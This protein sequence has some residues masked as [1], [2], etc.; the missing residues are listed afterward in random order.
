M[1]ARGNPAGNYRAI[2]VVPKLKGLTSDPKSKAKSIALSDK[3][4]QL[5]ESLCKKHFC[6][7]S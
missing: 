2:F 7:K 4:V 1:N 6:E 3:A 5:S